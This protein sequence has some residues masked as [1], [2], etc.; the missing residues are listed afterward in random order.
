VL[1]E[2]EVG[3]QRYPQQTDVVAGCYG[4]TA[5]STDIFLLIII[6]ASLV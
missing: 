3:R 5:R 4:V 2:A 1:V 6:P